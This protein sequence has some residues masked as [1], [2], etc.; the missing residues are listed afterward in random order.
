[1]KAQPPEPTNRYH[2]FTVVSVSVVS[3]LVGLLCGSAGSGPSAKAFVRHLAKDEEPGEEEEEEEEDPTVESTSVYAII[4]FLIV[5]T[6]MFEKTKDAVEE[7]STKDML[8][9]IESLFGEM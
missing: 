7:R 2:L 9:I 4:L 8:P 1:M 3:T 5:V 6:I